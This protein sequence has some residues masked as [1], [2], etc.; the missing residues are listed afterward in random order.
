MADKVQVLLVDDEP[1]VL[2]GL[3]RQLELRG[4]SWNLLFASGGSEALDLMAKEP[5][6]V[7]ITDTHM[8][9]LDGIALLQEVT[10]R[11]PQTIRFVLSGQ[12][13][14]EETLKMAGLA[15]QI[16]HKPCD[17]NTLHTMLAQALNM[18]RLLT[19]P[20]LR[21]L[22]SQLNTLPTMPALFQTLLAEIQSS[23]A[24]VKRVGQIIAQDMAMTAKILQLV[25]S[26]FF[27]LRQHVTDPAQAVI[28]LG[29]DVVKALVLSA[30]VFSQF[31]A[32]KLGGIDPER[33]QGHSLS[34]AILARRIAQAEQADNMLVDFAFTAGL[35]HDLGQLILATNLPQAY[36][37]V[38]SLAS[39]QEIT[40]VEAEQRLLG[41]AHPEVGAY[42]LGIWGLPQP[43]VEALAYHHNP[44]A[45]LTRQFGPLAIVHV[46]DCL[47]WEL[48]ANKSVDQVPQLDQVYLTELNIMD[49]LPHWQEMSQQIV[50]NERAS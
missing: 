41:A 19:S 8:P 14:K 23:E 17:A 47:V 16:L 44:S 36:E 35:L 3:R 2:R 21:A 49:R 50:R 28:F 42:L 30:H 39:E 6:D 38:L 43:V 32:A 4:D 24:D 11:F 26:A 10:T 5:C 29:L 22:A 13:N 27:G 18:Q 20:E 7:L 34:V 37:Q 46:A 25:N 15:H 40:L 1:R 48:A 33:L 45:C 12:M 9:G 31:D